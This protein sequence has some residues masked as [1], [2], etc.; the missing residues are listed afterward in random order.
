M[1][2]QPSAQVFE[3]A[4]LNASLQTGLRNPLDEAIT[5]QKQ[6]DITLDITAWRKVGE[7]PM[8]SSASASAS[9]WKRIS[10]TCSLPK[11]H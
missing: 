6:L 5:A 7:G 1:A 3:F 8:I 9:L 10:S 4:Y 2:G 11:V